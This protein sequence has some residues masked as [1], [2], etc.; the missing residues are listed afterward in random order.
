MVG[1]QPKF[2]IIH[3]ARTFALRT[4]VFLTFI[5]AN[6]INRQR[7]LALP[8]RPFSELTGTNLAQL[9]WTYTALRYLRKGAYLR[10]PVIAAGADNRGG[11]SLFTIFGANLKRITEEWLV[12]PPLVR[13]VLN[14]TLQIFFP[15][16]AL[17][18]RLGMAQFEEERL[19]ALLYS[20]FPGNFRFY[21][22]VYPVLKLP[23]TLA[24]IWLQLCRV[25]NR[26]DRAMGNPLLR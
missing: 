8:H 13:V 6:I 25:V 18:T 5:T 26:V 4:H 11:L 14:G 20:L 17:Q 3:D 2:E 24:R 12:D 9:S 23:K 10:E 15:P 21:F 19:D 1:R 16:W 7:V 22:F